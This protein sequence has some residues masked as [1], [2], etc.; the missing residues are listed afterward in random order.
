MPMKIQSVL[1]YFYNLQYVAGRRLTFKENKE[2]LLNSLNPEY[3]PIRVTKNDDF[4]IA[5]VVK[6]VICNHTHP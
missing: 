2:I 3:S 6:G 5:G 1:N 4:Y